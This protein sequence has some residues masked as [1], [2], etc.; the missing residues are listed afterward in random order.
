MRDKLLP[1]NYVDIP[2]WKDLADAI[3]VVFAEKVDGPVK[4]LYQLRDSFPYRFVEWGTETPYGLFDVTD[5]Y[6]FPK[7]EYILF[8]NFL[9]FASSNSLFFREDF[10][11]LYSNIGMFYMEGKGTE[12][13]MN[14]YS[15]CI[16]ALFSVDML[17]TEDYVYFYQESDPLV[18]TPVYD[19]G[20][21]YPTSHVEITYDFVKFG[22]FS[23]EDMLDFFYYVAPINLV[24]RRVNF[25]SD[26]YSGNDVDA[27]GLFMGATTGPIEIYFLGV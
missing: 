8:N 15:Y 20:T 19:G 4:L 12:A 26:I 25:V 13:F 6:P 10:Q 2:A 23:S 7:E 3:D 27:T 21:W 1:P 14:F 5:L 9:G 16:G 18:G 22:V 17:W 24:L 11:T